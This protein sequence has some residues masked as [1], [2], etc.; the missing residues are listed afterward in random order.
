MKDWSLAQ[1]EVA[2]LFVDTQAGKISVAEFASKAQA[3][4]ERLASF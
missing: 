2:P 3:A 1:A 4:T